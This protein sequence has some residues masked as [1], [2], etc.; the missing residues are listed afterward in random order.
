M[1]NEPG[2]FKAHLF[3]WLLLHW[4]STFLQHRLLE[5]HQGWVHLVMLGLTEE[6]YESAELVTIYLKKGVKG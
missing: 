5:D 1:G 3:L 4:T 6:L 2:H